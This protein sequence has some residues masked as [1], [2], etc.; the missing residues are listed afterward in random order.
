VINDGPGLLLVVEK[1][2]WANTLQATHGVKKPSMSYVPE[3]ALD[4]LTIFDRL[5]SSS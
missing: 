1:Y 3:P 4:G 5:T 2:P